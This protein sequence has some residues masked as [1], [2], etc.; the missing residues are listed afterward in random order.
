MHM[1]E[2]K[3]G[4]RIARELER[5]IIERGWGAGHF[6]GREEDVAR[7]IGASRAIVREAIAI[8]EMD[9]FIECRRGQ[10][11]GVYVGIS[12]AD[13]RNSMLRNYLVF[14]GVDGVQIQD[15]RL[16]IEKILC[17]AV[18]RR[19]T[20]GEALRLRA[21][22]Q[23]PSDR[24]A[25]SFAR[26]NMV[27]N[28][29]IL[30]LARLPSLAFLMTPLLQASID[31]GVWNG[32]SENNV[33]K[34]SAETAELRRDLVEALISYDDSRMLAIQH[35]ISAAHIRWAERHASPPTELEDAIQRLTLLG[36]KFAMHSADGRPVKKP[37][38]VARL[39]A[40]IANDIRS[41][42]DRLGS[43]EEMIGR[44]GVSGGVFRE[45]VR[46]LERYGIVRVRR[47]NDGGLFRQRFNP[48]GVVG[49]VGLFI[50][51]T[52]AGAEPLALRRAV[53][54]LGRAAAVSIVNEHATGQPKL[55]LAL[56]QG[57]NE[58]KQ[59]TDLFAPYRVLASAVSDQVVVILLRALLR[60]L[61]TLGDGIVEA[62]QSLDEM[63]A[64]HQSFYEYLEA[65][66]LPMARR[67]LVELGTVASVDVSIDA[68]VEVVAQ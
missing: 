29:E 49:A 53:H 2:L 4:E 15:A 35:Q 33:G 18:A 26:H 51:T 12:A 66:D 19:A 31:I 17:E 55:K 25:A 5:Q 9:G 47:G 16:T 30:S 50:A 54:R 56:E 40:A 32:A 46:T 37:Q 44:L 11:G 14:A 41:A 45:A 42:D 65:K 28:H 23:P 38:A 67:C 7:Q 48:E 43:E 21:L 13:T 36:Q 27:L 8:A 59:G 3:A 10:A 34:L 52:Q 64:L 68:N 60:A 20:K 62:P 63:H 6:L 1:N 22:A 58:L 39:I 24:S 57:R 61:D